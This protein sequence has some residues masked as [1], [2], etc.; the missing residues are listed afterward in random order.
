MNFLKP[1]KLKI[2]LTLPLLFL[3]IYATFSFMIWTSIGIETT[4][5]D[6]LLAASLTDTVFQL[7]SVGGIAGL[8]I[9]NFL[10]VFTPVIILLT[11]V[12]VFQLFWSYF[13]S[14]LF[15]LVYKKLS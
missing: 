7:L 4:L 8:I 1:N 11:L 3:G 5:L 10:A 9:G 13:L 2:I 15:V 14:C 6:H 12:G